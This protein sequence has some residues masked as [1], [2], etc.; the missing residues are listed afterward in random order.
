MFFTLNGSS[1]CNASCSS[2]QNSLSFTSHTF[3]NIHPSIHF[4]RGHGGSCLSRNAQT[5][6]ILDVSSSSSGRI[7]RHSQACPG[8]SSGSP[9]GGVSGTP[10]EGGAS[11]INAPNLEGASHLFPVKNHGLRLGGADFHPSCFTLGC[12]PPQDM[13]EVLA[14]WSQQDNIIRKM[15]RWVRLKAVPMPLMTDIKTRLFTSPGMA[16]PG[17]HPGTRPGVGAPRR[18][19]GGRVLA[20]GT[21]PGSARK[22]DVGPPSS[23]F[24]TRRRV[25]KGLVSCNLG[26]G[27][28]QGPRRPNPWTVTLA[29]GTWNVASLGERA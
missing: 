25:Q 17:P 18:V 29:M 28:G 5:S 19:P 1:L 20:H 27:C 14:Q 8:S 3:C 22:S 6:P 23:R 12:K 10:P 9:P 11:D 21:W 24:T 4:L 15:Q 7:P 26:G 13:L 2:E 16:L